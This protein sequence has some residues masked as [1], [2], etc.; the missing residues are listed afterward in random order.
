MGKYKGS[1]RRRWDRKNGRWWGWLNK[2]KSD[3]GVPEW[4][5]RVRKTKQFQKD[6]TTEWKGTGKAWETRGNILTRSGD[7]PVPKMRTVSVIC[8]WDAFVLYS[9]PESN[10]FLSTKKKNML[11]NNY[12]NTIFYT[13][14]FLFGWLLFSH[15]VIIIFVV[16]F[17]CGLIC[18]FTMTNYV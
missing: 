14:N 9:F 12:S 1:S 3:D 15:L 6:E 2:K 7:W 13:W 16:E 18:I 4:R 11:H 8:P 10:Q 17:Y 5:K